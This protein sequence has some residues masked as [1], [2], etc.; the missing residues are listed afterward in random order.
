MGYSS[1][2]MWWLQSA[3]LDLYGAISYL[4]HPLRLGNPKQFSIESFWT[5][6]ISSFLCVP[7][8][9]NENVRLLE[10]IESLNHPSLTPSLL[11]RSKKYNTMPHLAKNNTWTS[12][13]SSTS[14][15][16][17]PISLSLSL[18]L[19]YKP[20]MWVNNE[21]IKCIMYNFEWIKIL[22]KRRLNRI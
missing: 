5:S 18:S 13:S 4:G 2:S 16:F 1:V 3:Q 7:L 14:F 20:Y 8:L 11:K 12:F 17:S 6:W 9:Y 15:Y 22:L 10:S 19:S 21:K